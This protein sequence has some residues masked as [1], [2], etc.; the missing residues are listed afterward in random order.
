MCIRTD[1]LMS[2]RNSLPVPQKRR[3]R[4]LGRRWRLSA[5]ILQHIATPLVL[6]LLAE[7]MGGAA[8]GLFI[9]SGVRMVFQ[10]TVLAVGAVVIYLTG[11]G[12]AANWRERQR[13]L[14][15]QCI[16]CGYDLR[17]TPDR[18]PECGRKVH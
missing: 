9:G 5:V 3:P 6:L 2:M 1:R 15:G 10:L 12:A 18:C 11:L 17:R 7:I 8:I 13:W 4:P 16:N 14:H